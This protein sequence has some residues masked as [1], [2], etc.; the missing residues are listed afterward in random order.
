M[1]IMTKIILMKKA[2]KKFKMRKNNQYL[3]VRI[4]K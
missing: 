3:N 1:K 4:Q 2:R